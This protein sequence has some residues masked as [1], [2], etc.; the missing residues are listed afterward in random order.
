MTDP[1]V[2]GDVTNATL[3]MILPDGSS[4]NYP[5]TAASDCLY[6]LVTP[7]ESGQMRFFVLTES[8]YLATDN[9]NDPL[10]L[11]IKPSGWPPPVTDASY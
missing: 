4:K 6:A 3:T 11:E 10:L 8:P 7:N 2:Y 5:M 1:A 9:E